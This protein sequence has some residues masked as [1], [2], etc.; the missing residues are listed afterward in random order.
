MARSMCQVAELSVTGSPLPQALIL[1]RQRLPCELRLRQLDIL[2]WTALESVSTNSAVAPPTISV[3]VE[4]ARGPA[5][6][7]VRDFTP[8]PDLPMAPR[9]K[10][11]AC[12]DR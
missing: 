7:P 10:T 1:L 6:A 12:R 2:S 4:F 3:V 5:P 8:H 9:K 11:A